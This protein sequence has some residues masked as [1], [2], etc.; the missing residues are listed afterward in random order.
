[1][2][3][4]SINQINFKSV[5]PTKY[6][7]YEPAKKSYYV[8]SD[9]PRIQKLQQKFVRSLNKDLNSKTINSKDFNVKELVAMDSD[10]RNSPSVRS[11]YNKEGRDFS[12]SNRYFS[13]LLTGEDALYIN[14]L[15]KEIGKNKKDKNQIEINKSTKEYYNKGLEYVTKKSKEFKDDNNNNYILQ[16]VF[17]I[18]RNTKGA[19][20]DFQFKAAKF[21][22]IVYKDK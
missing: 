22:K 12:S 8:I 5:I 13:Y 11:F 15:G 14:N 19:I 21:T 2:Q 4:C 1:M 10:Y 17:E 7:L 3:V 18:V 9:I 16:I 6:W 20:K